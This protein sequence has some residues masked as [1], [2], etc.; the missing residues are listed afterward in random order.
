MTSTAINT[1]G[2]TDYGDPS[3]WVEGQLIYFDQRAARSLQLPVRRQVVRIAFGGTA[4]NG[5]YVTTI[6]RSDGTSVTVTTT[7]SGGSPSTNANLATQHALDVMAATGAKGVI[8]S[9][10]VAS[11]TNV[12]ITFKHHGNT[13]TVECTAPGS[14]T[15]SPTTTQVATGETIKAG[16]FATISTLDGIASI[17][18]IASGD[19]AVLGVVHRRGAGPRPNAPSI[20]D[21][22]SWSAPDVVTLHTDCAMVMRNVSASAATIGATVYAVCNTAGG[23]EV[24]QAR[25]TD[26]GS[27]SFE[28]T[29]AWWE[30]PAPAG[31]L[32]IVRV[33]I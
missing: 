21:A 20:D 3:Q 13:Y 1:V 10:A 29:R 8:Y 32:G 16:R 19:T 18:N 6:T 25:A 4:S 12:D 2:R 5:D 33:R 23:D 27:N 7:R 22:P 14:G 15:L 26:D 30:T 9:A 17:R 11:S 28:V 24:G 31:G